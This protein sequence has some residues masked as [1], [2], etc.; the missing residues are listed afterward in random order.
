MFR[1][2]RHSVGGPPPAYWTDEFKR[3]VGIAVQEDDRGT[4]IVVQYGRSLIFSILIKLAA[5]L[6]WLSRM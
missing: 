4:K 1:T 5:S 2:G 6:M 3:I